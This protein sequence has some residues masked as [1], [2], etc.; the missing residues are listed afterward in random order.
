[1]GVDHVWLSRYYPL[2]GE[3]REKK[4]PFLGPE[5][6][7]KAV[8]E[9]AQLCKRFKTSAAVISQEANFGQYLEGL[10]AGFLARKNPP[11]ICKDVPEDGWAVF[12]ALSFNNYEDAATIV[13]DAGG[14]NGK[15]VR[16]GTK[17]DWNTSLAPPVRGQYRVF[18][19]LRC[20]GKI[21]EGKV[22]SW[23]VYDSQGKKSLKDMVL[24][25]KDFATEDGSLDKK[26]RWIDMGVVDFVAGAYIW[27]AHG[28]SPDL[29]AIFVDRVVLIKAE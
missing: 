21:K 13:D 11:A 6:P 16:M 7:V 2:R 26:F 28:H 27:F 29:D 3:S 24:S 10:K 9:F 12:D 19:S 8:E 20:E 4:L 14:A 18:A 5:D 15:S 1:M 25:P 23:G 22:G 17:V